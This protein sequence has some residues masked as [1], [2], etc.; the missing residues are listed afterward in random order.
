[1]PKMRM[2]RYALIVFLLLPLITFAETHKMKEYEVIK[3]DCLWN[4][5]KAELND[6]FMWPQIWKENTWIADPHWI[7][8]GQIIKIPVYLIQNQQQ[9]QEVA[10][11]P[12]ATSPATPSEEIKKEAVPVMKQSLVNKDLLLASGYIADTIPGVGKIGDSPSRQLS[13]GNDDFVFVNID[14]PA[15]K[16][17]KF[18]VL[19]ISE[20][21]KH[22]VTG[23]NIGYVITIAGI[24]EIVRIQ[25]GETMAIIKKCFGEI[26]SGD[27]LVPYYDIET[28]MTTG[29]FRS[30]DI[31]GM[32]IAAGN[33]NLF[34]S[35]L[36]IVYI[37]KGCKDGIEA[38]DMFRTIAVEDYAM[39]NGVIQ[40]VSCRDHTATAIIK[41]STALILPGNIFA[42]L[43]NN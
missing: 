18:Y 16:G 43:G 4:I 35:M 27:R 24:A 36:D 41:S 29:H 34:Q 39:P 42:T 17:D 33:N 30:P 2:I 25:N 22:P 31:N 6:P 38:G 32:I 9:E 10:P 21:L 26:V 15:Q 23:E 37:D 19:K 7:Y 40:V 14:H 5:S 20:P 13:L 1:M 28:P 12:T 3:G 8:P 11:I